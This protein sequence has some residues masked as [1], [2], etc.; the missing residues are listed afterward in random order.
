MTSE[1]D[2]ENGRYQ[3]K[4]LRI[5]PRR[6]TDIKPHPRVRVLRRD[7]AGFTIIEARLKSNEGV[8]WRCGS[9]AE[10]PNHNLQICP[11]CGKD[12]ND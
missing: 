11:V 8:C 6:P 1:M 9:I 3:K 12:F 5:L 4:Q 10:D 2:K 7:N